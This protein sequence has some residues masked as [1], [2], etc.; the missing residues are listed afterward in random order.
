MFVIASCAVFA[1]T[2]TNNNTMSSS[3][4][5]SGAV[6]DEAALTYIAALCTSLVLYGGSGEQ[7]SGGVQGVL[8]GH[9]GH[10]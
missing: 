4:S 1:Q 9:C 7:G 8:V 3:S 10:P 6:L 2:D 5:Y